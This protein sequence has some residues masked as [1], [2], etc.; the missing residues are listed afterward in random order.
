MYTILPGNQC[1]TCSNLL[2]SESVSFFDNKKH[3]RCLACRKPHET[4]PGS[5]EYLPME[6]PE[7]EALPNQQCPFLNSYEYECIS[8]ENVEKE[9]IDELCTILNPILKNYFDFV[10]LNAV[11][12]IAEELYKKGY[13]KK[14]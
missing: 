10:P 14:I 1:A 9:K 3:Y 5:I 4:Y 7:F 2:C 11:V 13:H 8:F 12:G 6:L